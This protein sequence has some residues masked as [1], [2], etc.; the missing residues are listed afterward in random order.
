MTHRTD[1]RLGS[2]AKLQEAIRR[3]RGF[4]SENPKLPSLGGHH[5]RNNFRKNCQRCVPV[6]A[7][8]P[9]RLLLALNEMR[10]PARWTAHTFGYYGR[11]WMTGCRVGGVRGYGYET[12]RA[13]DKPVLGT[14]C[15]DKDAPFSRALTPILED[16]Q[17][18]GDFQ[19]RTLILLLMGAAGG[20]VP[21]ARGETALRSVR[22]RLGHWRR[23]LLTGD[24]FADNPWVNATNR[25]YGDLQSAI[26]Q[27]ED[28]LYA[29]WTA[30]AE[31]VCAT[32][33]TRRSEMVEVLTPWLQAPEIIPA[34]M[35]WTKCVKFA[36][37]WL[38]TR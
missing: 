25:R 29:L 34:R 18:W 22:D 13:L 20:L 5:A 36:E 30:A 17:R 19:D 14:A 10:Q 6:L 4:D 24:E 26:R 11:S 37:E 2:E 38:E 32:K 15:M 12:F 28:A 16:P 8:H 21:W 7:Q 33:P 31:A 35:K 27:Q 1:A 3:G 9:E 23:K